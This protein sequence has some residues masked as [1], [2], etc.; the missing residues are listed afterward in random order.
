MKKLLVMAAIVGLVA[1]IAGPAT[2]GGKGKGRGNQTAVAAS[3]ITPNQTD[4]HH[5]DSVTFSVAYSTGNAGI[6]VRCWQNGQWIYQRTGSVL[7]EFV[8]T[9]A[10]WTSGGGNCQADLYHDVYQGQSLVW[11]E[12]LAQTTFTVA[13]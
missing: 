4:L 11:R 8:L 9:T 13:A 1:I 7:A 6:W 3:S 12:W 10:D 5:G 2:A